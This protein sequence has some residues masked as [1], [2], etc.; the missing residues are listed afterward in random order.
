METLKIR[1]E[2][3]CDSC[4]E[5]Y[6]AYYGD[7]LIGYLRLRHGHFTVQYPDVGGR[8]VYE[9]YPEGDGEFDNHERL[10]Y[11]FMA[12]TALLREIKRNA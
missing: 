1:L 11:L 7:K 8:C 2:K 3:T 10:G 4:P 5:Q 9:A 6:D 12:E